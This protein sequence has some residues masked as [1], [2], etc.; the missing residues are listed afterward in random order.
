MLALVLNK[1]FI[2]SDSHLN[3]IHKNN[4]Q[5]DKKLI[6]KNCDLFSKLFQHKTNI[7]FLSL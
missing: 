7:K 1:M 6:I 4:D 2:K 3:T 5:T